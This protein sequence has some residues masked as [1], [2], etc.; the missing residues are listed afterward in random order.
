MTMTNS[1]MQSAITRVTGSGT[2]LVELQKE[3]D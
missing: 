1:D 3:T 2:I